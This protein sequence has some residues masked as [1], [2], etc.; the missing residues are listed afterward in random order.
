MCSRRLS[1]RWGDWVVAP[2]IIINPHARKGAAAALKPA[3]ENFLASEG[4]PA[5][6]VV[7]GT[8]ESLRTVFADLVKG[9]R[10][11]AVG[12]DGTN[13]QLL[14]YLLLG[15]HEYGL[16]PYGSGDDVARAAGL[17]GQR[18]QQALRH[19]LMAQPQRVDVA[20]VTDRESGRERHFFGCFLLGMDAHINNQ[21]SHWKFKGPLPYF[22]TLLKELPRLRGWDL[23][24]NWETVHGQ[25]GQASG[26][27]IL[28]SILNTSTYG[29]GYPIAPMARINDGALDLLLAP[30]VSRWRFVHLFFKMLAGQHVNSPHASFHAIKHL[31][32]RSPH[33]L[34]LSA[35]GEVLDWHT[36]HLELRV[37]PH[38]IP[39]VTGDIKNP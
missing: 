11:I 10:V 17:F 6:V 28:C 1:W 25:T 35:D 34:C 22:A 20:V 27:M 26:W 2:T 36:R 39:M 14:P 33:P 37:L 31:E 5:R 16:L 18:W 4:L 21:T 24:L 12:G 23:R 30:M 3:I 32:V 15:Q 38:A 7:C 13:H 9:S 29:S 19:A 8:P